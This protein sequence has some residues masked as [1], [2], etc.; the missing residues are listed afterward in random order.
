[1]YKSSSTVRNV[2]VESVRWGAD[3]GAYCIITHWTSTDPEFE[4]E[5]IAMTE[6]GPEMDSQ[7]NAFQAT[8]QS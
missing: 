7:M 3:L 6:R 2:L 5:L 8:M 1:M 4:K